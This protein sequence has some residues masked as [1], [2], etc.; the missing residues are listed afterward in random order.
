MSPASDDIVTDN[1][2]YVYHMISPG[3]QKADR[4]FRARCRLAKNPEP[5]GAQQAVSISS[6]VP[7]NVTCVAC[8]LLHR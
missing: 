7:A 5:P 3:A 6:R 8:W 1:E 2:D 4:E